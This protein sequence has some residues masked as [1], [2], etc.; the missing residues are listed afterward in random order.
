MVKL[1]LIFEGGIYTNNVSVDTST[2]MESLR[3]SVH[4]FF[5]RLLNTEEVDIVLYLGCGYR[6][7][8]KKFIKDKDNSVLFVDSDCSRDLVSQWYDRLINDANP[9]KSILIPD[10][11]KANV[12]FMV[13]EMEAWFLK[14][15]DVLVRW[16]NVQKYKRK[17]S[18]E[19]I[20]D[21]SLIRNKDVEDIAKPSEKLNQIIKHFFSKGKKG[22]RYGKLKSAPEIL[23]CLDTLR[24]IDVD[25]DLLRFKTSFSK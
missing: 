25:E 7:A 19:S 18:E 24:L 9:D 15:P 14:Q 16:A 17:H 2:N 6:N 10:D 22:V 23:D 5:S 8:V 21:H 4:Q 12:F 13:Q 20:K 1:N 3:Q 11:K